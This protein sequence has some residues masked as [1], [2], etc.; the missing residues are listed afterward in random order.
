MDTMF[1]CKCGRVH[2]NG[3]ACLAAAVLD[4]M[5]SKPRVK[6]LIAVQRLEEELIGVEHRAI[7]YACVFG[8]NWDEATE[9]MKLQTRL[10]VSGKEVR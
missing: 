10:L 7:N 1:A 3:E 8:M 9:E 6:D 5:E 4:L 2:F